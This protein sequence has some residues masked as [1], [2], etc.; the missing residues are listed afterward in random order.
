MSFVWYEPIRQDG[1]IWN[2][3]R[4]IEMERYKDE[5]Q[6]SRPAEGIE[7]SQAKV[8]SI[9]V[10]AGSP[11][12][13]AQQEKRPAKILVGHSLGG[14]CAAAEVIDNP[15]VCLFPLPLL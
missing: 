11:D 6:L 13:A 4:C 1:R 10:Q 14:A 15:E 8:I 7:M 3:H 12:R 5:L 2:S 9:D